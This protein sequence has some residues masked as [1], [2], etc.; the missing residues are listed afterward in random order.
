MP[1]NK[2]SSFSRQLPSALLLGFVSLCVFPTVVYA[3]PDHAYSGNEYA[4][5][6][7]QTGCDTSLTYAK[8]LSDPTLYTGKILEVSGKIAGRSSDG[9]NLSVVL[10]LSDGNTVSLDLPVSA[11]DALNDD[12]TARVRFLAQVGTTAVSNIPPLKA[13]GF[14]H[15]SEIRKLEL[16]EEAKTRAAKELEERKR[17]KAERWKK[18]A[19]RAMAVN[20]AASSA[21]SANMAPP[22]VNADI[23]SLQNYLGPRARGI[24]WPYYKYIAKTNER[25]DATMVGKI[26]FHLL[27]FADHNNVDPRL[28]V[29]MI[30]AESH[31]DP[32]ATSHAGAMG[33]GQL[34]PGTARSLGVDNPYDPI[35]NLGGSINYLRSRLDT[36]SDHALPGGGVSFEQAA[37][38]M[39]AY[40]AG[41][42]AVKR[43]NGIPPYTQ[44]QNYVRKVISLY[45]I[46]CS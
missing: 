42:N 27:N 31:F 1:V 24:F 29:A 26:T 3:L 38:A 39:A 35:Q 21:A 23:A 46:L 14:V 32:N 36:F 11:A 28:V 18:E 43:Y 30:F 44:T 41:V 40:N 34:M 7:R 17:Q 45:K 13:L 8:I 16:A 22:P 19:E 33:L 2:P 4:A 10:A 5:M 6:R 15:E 12:P 20:A 37:L 9:V 25:L